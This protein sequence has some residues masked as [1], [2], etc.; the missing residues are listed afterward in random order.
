[1]IKPYYQDDYV[2][3]YNGDSNKLLPML[4][5][6]INNCLL[7]I[8]PPYGIGESDMKVKSRQCKGNGNSKALANQ[9][10]YGIFQWDNKPIS[11]EFIDYLISISRYSIVW[12]GN[13]YA[14]KPSPC[15]LVWDKLNGGNDFA[16]CELA[17]TN[18]PKSVR[19]IEHL[20]N[21]MLRANQEK[22][23]HPTQK[24]LGVIAWA[25]SQ[26]PSKYDV[27]LDCFSGSGTTG[28]ASK[29]LNKKCVLIELEEKYCEIAARRLSQEVFNF[30]E[31][32][33]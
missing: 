4:G 9:K 25:I 23:F 24:P 20:W 3:L 12:G 11:Q 31:V 1:M 13:Y 21:G 29:Q 14:M 19:K 15:W 8:D 18:L 7:L 30:E 17:W 28:V 2:T 10:D 22:R 33:Q 16:D 27:I 5:N 26:V 6:N 32:K